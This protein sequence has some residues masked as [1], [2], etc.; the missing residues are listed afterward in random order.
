M[1]RFEFPQNTSTTLR[2]DVVAQRGDQ[3]GEGQ[4]GMHGARVD[5]PHASAR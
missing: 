5:E 2:Q 4:G 1:T 3:V